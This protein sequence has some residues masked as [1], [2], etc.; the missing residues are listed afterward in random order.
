MI[1]KNKK[2]IVIEKNKKKYD[3]GWINN[4]TWPKRQLMHEKNLPFTK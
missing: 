4:L 3:V 2:E 1:E